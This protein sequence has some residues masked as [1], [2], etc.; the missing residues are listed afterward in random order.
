[1]QHKFLIPEDKVLKVTDEQGIEVDEDVFPELATEAMCFVIS[2][3]DGKGIENFWACLFFAES[4]YRFVVMFV[5]LSQQ[6]AD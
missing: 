2:T 6:L 5:K 1:V 4:F 3:D